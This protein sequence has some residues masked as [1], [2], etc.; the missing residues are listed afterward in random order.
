MKQFTHEDNSNDYRSSYQRYKTL[1][2]TFSTWLFSTYHNL[3]PA[4]GDSHKASHKKNT[5]NSSNSSKH[6]VADLER[7]ACS[8]VE[9]PNHGRH[10]VPKSIL[11]CL[12]KVIQRRTEAH[13]YYR[14]RTDSDSESNDSHAHFIGILEKIF[15]ILGGEEWLEEQ[16]EMRKK[17]TKQMDEWDRKKEETSSSTCSPPNR[18]LQFSPDIDDGLAISDSE[19][20]ETDS[21]LPQH[22]SGGSKSGGRNKRRRSSATARQSRKRYND[23]YPDMQFREDESDELFMQFCFF[24]DLNMLR[25]QV[26][27]I[28][29]EWSQCP[30]LDGLVVA[31]TA[32]DVVVGIAERLEQRFIEQDPT[33]SPLSASAIHANLAAFDGLVRASDDWTV[34]VMEPYFNILSG[35]GS[36]SKAGA[37][38][39]PRLLTLPGFGVGRE[40]GTDN[41]DPSVSSESKTRQDYWQTF[42]GR[43]AGELEVAHAHPVLHHGDR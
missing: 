18:F 37:T 41:S 1:S 2:T 10:K 14:Q 24:D 36:R 35:S 3:L 20:E 29:L 8:I 31:A 27:R 26:K 12:Y 9:A 21:W 17:Q 34:S 25:C 42:M 23:A 13:N 22:L 15:D 16:L 33:M 40:A 6:S 43:V 7:I 32:T 11:N 39:L 19:D 30:S 4:R 5:K 38:S 28:W